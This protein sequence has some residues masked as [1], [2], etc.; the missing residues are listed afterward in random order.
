MDFPS[1]GAYDE[2]GQCQ[3]EVKR[4]EEERSGVGA[5]GGWQ[6]LDKRSS[7]TAENRVDGLIHI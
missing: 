5:K 7:D 3:L 4:R 2:L 6:V 1:R